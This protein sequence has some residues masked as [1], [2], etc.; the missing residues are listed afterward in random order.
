[1]VERLVMRRGLSSYDP[2]DTS[3]KFVTLYRAVKKRTLPLAATALYV[4]AKTS[5][6]N[7]QFGDA[8]AQFKDLLVL[9]SDPEQAATL[10]DLKLL[11]EGFS[12]LSEQRLADVS[13]P[14][15]Q[16]P[17]AANALEV[18]RVKAPGGF[19]RR[20]YGFEDLEVVPPTLHQRMPPW[21][22]P[23]PFLATR[24][25]HGILEIVVGEDGE[26]ESQAMSE[27]TF[28]SVTGNCSGSRDDGRYTP[29]IRD[30]RPV[31]YR[32]AIAVTLGGS[33]RNE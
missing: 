21:I 25:L 16:P 18:P 14:A 8:S 15:A 5:F 20:V 13:T 23:G 31:K 19:S 24:V 33:A 22:P 17:P 26:V 4:S 29:A 32:K 12:R 28:P 3:P 2:D 30:G 10:G 6:E 7:A 27:P 11:A 9:L 1:M